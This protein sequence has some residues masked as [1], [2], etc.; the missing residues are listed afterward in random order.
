[1]IIDAYWCHGCCMS[2][3]LD[4]TLAENWIVNSIILLIDAY[5]PPLP[6]DHLW[7][8]YQKGWTIEPWYVINYQLRCLPTD[9]SNFLMH[10]SFRG[11]A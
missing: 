3:V 5:C 4:L 8:I 1:M 7:Y 9:V 2:S 6:E 11:E 10:S